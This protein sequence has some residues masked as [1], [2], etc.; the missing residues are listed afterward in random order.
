M[1]TIK[2]IIVDDEAAARE[3][4]FAQLNRYCPEVQIVATCASV[5]EA[6]A[7]IDLHKPALV[8]I[9]QTRMVLNS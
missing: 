2:T 7:N 8:L 6:I 3:V 1:K 9:C 5:D 4:L